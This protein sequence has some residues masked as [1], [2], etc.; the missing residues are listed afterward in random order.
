M[1]LQS[2]FFLLCMFISLSLFF[3]FNYIYLVTII[4]NKF[5]V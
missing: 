3:K 4:F 2:E 1:T 5:T